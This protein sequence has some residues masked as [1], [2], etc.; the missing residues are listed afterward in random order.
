V[1]ASAGAGFV[2]PLAG[3]IRTIPGLGV[4]PA[5]NGIDLDDDGNVIGLS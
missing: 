1:G 5:A 4:R 3:D 2:L